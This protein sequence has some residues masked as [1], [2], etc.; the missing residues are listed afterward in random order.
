MDIEGINYT[1]E[2]NENTVEIMDMFYEQLSNFTKELLV[3]NESQRVVITVNDSVLQI[4]NFVN[5]DITKDY[6]KGG[7]EV[8]EIE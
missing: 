6:I 8:E 2:N 3:L 5:E 1:T 7:F 4:T